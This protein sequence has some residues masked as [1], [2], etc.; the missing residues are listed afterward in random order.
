MTVT[1]RH[2]MSFE[3]TSTDG[4][5]RVRAAKAGRAQVV[6]VVDRARLVITKGATTQVITTRLMGCVRFGSMTVDW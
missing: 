3:V 5:A 1:T 6:V 2:R 4:H